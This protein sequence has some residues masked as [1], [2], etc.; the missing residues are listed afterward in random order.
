[1]Y[2]FFDALQV[3]GGAVPVTTLPAVAVAEAIFWSTDAAVA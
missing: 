2:P 3:T 1:M